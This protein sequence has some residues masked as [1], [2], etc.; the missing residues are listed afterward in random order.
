MRREIVGGVVGLGLF[1]GAAV[2]SFP[3]GI[4]AAAGALGYIG[5]W[6]FTPRKKESHEILLDGGVSQAQLD[7][8]VARLRKSAAELATLEVRI[9]EAGMRKRVDDLRVMTMRI[10]ETVLKDPRDIRNEP[11][12]PMWSEEIVVRISTYAELA[13]AT[14]ETRRGSRQLDDCR[15]M[16]ER[17]VAAF[18]QIHHD[19]LDADMTE[20]SAGSRALREILETKIRQGQDERT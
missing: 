14:T 4:A 10:A 15:T 19:M 6:L 2:A 12:L 16:V 5:G 3:L 20:L 7:D 8:Y 17:A 1:A 9:V 13:A 11:S 18:E